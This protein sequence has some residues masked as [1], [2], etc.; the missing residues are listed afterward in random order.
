MRVPDKAGN[1]CEFL[2][3]TPKRLEW[4]KMHFSALKIFPFPK[5]GRKWT[6]PFFSPALLFTKAADHSAWAAL[7]SAKAAGLHLWFMSRLF[8]IRSLTLHVAVG[9]QQAH[10]ALKENNVSCCQQLIICSISETSKATLR[11][12]IQVPKWILIVAETQ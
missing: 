1:L 9:M 5:S 4:F 10:A 2:Q 8:P 6:A 3:Y 12:Q 7:A 11:L